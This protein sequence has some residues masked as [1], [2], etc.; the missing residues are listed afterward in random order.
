M[1]A[2]TM[3]KI[4]FIGGGNMAEAIVRGLVAG[5][6]VPSDHLFVSDP[7]ADRRD[8]LARSFGVQTTEDNRTVLD[9]CEVLVLAVKPQVMGT[10]LASVADAFRASH[11][12]ISIAAG[13]RTETL[14]SFCARTPAIIRVMPNTPAL[15]GKG[16]SAMCAGPRAAEVHLALAETLFASVGS[17]LRVDESAMDAVTAISGSGPAYVFYWMEAMLSAAASLGF[18]P[19]TA[20]QLVYETIS[21]SAAL[22]MGSTDT[23]DTL[24]AK[25]TSK[26]GTT[27]AAIKTLDLYQVRDH[28]VEAVKAAARRSQELS[29]LS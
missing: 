6:V 23:P 13:L 10:A 17:T 19:E 25:V 24:R 21:G 16:V 2:M 12:V 5:K 29:K 8:L 3:K 9:A 18:S 27:E 28:V 20:R 22:A 15:V 26:G 14:D 7:S 4:G 1:N 11:L